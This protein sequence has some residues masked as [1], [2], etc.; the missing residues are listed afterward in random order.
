MFLPWPS[1]IERRLVKSE[2]EAICG[3]KV[4]RK[5]FGVNKRYRVIHYY[6]GFTHRPFFTALRLGPI[7]NKH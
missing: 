7:V 1:K 4:D 2:R 3:S 5:E 6:E